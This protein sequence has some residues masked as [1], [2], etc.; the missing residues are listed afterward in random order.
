MKHFYTFYP[1]K[2]VEIEIEGP[3]VLWYSIK[4]L[5]RA[6]IRRKFKKALSTI[7]RVDC[8][9]STEYKGIFFSAIGFSIYIFTG[10]I[11]DRS[12]S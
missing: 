4:D 10:K 11:P 3:L 1:H 8:P 2:R 9:I 7:F 5:F 6:L 12:L